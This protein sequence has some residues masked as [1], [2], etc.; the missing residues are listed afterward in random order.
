MLENRREIVMDVQYDQTSGNG[1]AGNFVSHLTPDGYFQFLG[2]GAQ[3]SNYQRPV[4]AEF[5]NSFAPKDLRL[6]QSILDSF[7]YN[8]VTYYY[9]F[10]VKFVDKARYGSRYNWGVNFPVLRYTDVLML[11]AECTLHGGGGSQADVNDIVRK[12]RMRAGDSATV[13]NITLDSLFAERRKEFVAEGNRWFDLQRS[14]K[15]VQIMQEW[16]AKTDVQNKVNAFNANFILYPIPQSQLN[17]KPGLYTQN[18]GYD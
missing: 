2:L 7:K 12:V 5:R 4:S 13:S 11:R 10:Y 17:I 1:A 6:K 3:G 15:I 9:P 8:N 16:D 14:G 18:P